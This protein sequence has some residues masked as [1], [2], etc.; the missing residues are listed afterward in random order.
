MT[1]F[2][3]YYL[4]LFFILMYSTPLKAESEADSRPILGWVEYIQLQ[5]VKIIMKARIDTG[6]GLASVDANI[7]KITRNEHPEEDKVLF[8]IVDADGKSRTLERPIV[9]WV[10]IKKKGDEGTIKR[11]VVRLDFCMGGKKI[12]GRINLAD[13]E[14]F[15]YPLLIGRNILEVG[16]FMIDPTDKFMNEPECK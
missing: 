10:N 16:N 2:N 6:A 7:K 4:S 3:L 13:R 1:R 9:D 11:P 8:E 14:G 12:E 5:D 15:L